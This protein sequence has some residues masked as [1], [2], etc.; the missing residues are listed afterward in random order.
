MKNIMLFEEFTTDTVQKNNN[1]Y[2]EYFYFYK[3]KNKN[4]SEIVAWEVEGSQEKNF[5]LICKYINTGDTILDYGCGIGDFIKYLNKNDIEISNYMGVDI[6]GNFID[7]AKETYPLN[8]FQTIT[9]IND[10][11][12]KWDSVC[13]SGVF[14]WYIEKNDFIKTIRKLYNLCNKQ[15]LITCIYNKK[16]INVD[17]KKYW[18]TEFREYNEK[19]FTDLFPTLEFEFDFYKNYMLVRII[20]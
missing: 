14:T 11:T 12:E 2:D 19:L 9:N 16:H 17:S 4:R 8:N 3:N 5:D 1:L 15:V 10:I 13:A 18:K 20:K 6:N 7:V